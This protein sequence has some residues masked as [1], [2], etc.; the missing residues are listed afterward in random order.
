MAFNEREFYDKILTKFSE[1][2]SNGSKTKLVNNQS[3]KELMKAMS[4]KNDKLFTQNA[5]LLIMALFDEDLNND[6]YSN[7]KNIQKATKKNKE[8]IR[9]ILEEEFIS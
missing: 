1:S 7:T 2:N 5:L 6:F 4:G 8:I 3:I 9:S